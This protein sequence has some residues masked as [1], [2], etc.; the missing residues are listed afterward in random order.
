MP[1]LPFA[2]TKR[3]AAVVGGLTPSPDEGFWTLL[4][5]WMT[6]ISKTLDEPLSIP[7]LSLDKT[8]NDGIK[9]RHTV[10]FHINFKEKNKNKNNHIKIVF[11]NSFANN[12][13]RGGFST[14][15]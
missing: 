1:T 11:S 6:D 12:R 10:F 13:C 15:V 9:P 5:A 3:R 4:A 7:L 8:K 2:G 14:Q